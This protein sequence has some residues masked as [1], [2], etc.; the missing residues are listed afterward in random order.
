MVVFW[1]L[2]L[3][4]LVL[5]EKNQPE[6]ILD[7]RQVIKDALDIMKSYPAPT[8]L[9]QQTAHQQRALNSYYSQQHQNYYPPRRAHGTTTY[10]EGVESQVDKRFGGRADSQPNV[11]S[12]V[13]KFFATPT[14]QDMNK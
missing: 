1:P 4:H 9:M 13:T 11:I 2:L 12:E 6:R 3:L 5:A 14:Q 7:V 8:S 10:N